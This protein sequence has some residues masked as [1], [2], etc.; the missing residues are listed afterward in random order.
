MAITYYTD[1]ETKLTD[2]LNSWELYL[3][4]RAAKQTPTNQVAETE[5]H[6]LSGLEAEG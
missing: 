5:A 2:K 1:D 6:S 3:F 4:T